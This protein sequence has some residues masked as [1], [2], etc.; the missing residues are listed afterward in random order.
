VTS[1]GSWS[2]LESLER[3][4]LLTDLP[5][6]ALQYSIVEKGLAVVLRE[7]MRHM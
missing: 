2:E 5:R 6:V 3:R 4:D 1:E 7:L